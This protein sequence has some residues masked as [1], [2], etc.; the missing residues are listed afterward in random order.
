MIRRNYYQLN[1]MK[2]LTSTQCRDKL[3]VDN[4]PINWRT[5]EKLL[6]KFKIKPELITPQGTKLYDED[7]ISPLKHNLPKTRRPGEAYF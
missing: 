1:G 5:F 6:K 4:K 7:K 2:L 3:R